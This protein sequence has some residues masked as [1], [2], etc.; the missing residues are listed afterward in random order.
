MDVSFLEIISEICES[1]CS[2]DVHLPHNVQ[3]KK[4][5][6]QI[7]NILLWPVMFLD[8]FEK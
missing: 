6:E 3:Y 7:H 4:P 5:F 8:M 1:I 2:L